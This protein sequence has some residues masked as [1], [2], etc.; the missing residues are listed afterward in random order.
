[1]AIELLDRVIVAPVTSTIH[2]VPSEVAVGVESGLKEPSAVNLDN[3]QT[4]R[5]DRLRRYVGHL[6]AERMREVCQALALATG[7]M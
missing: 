5:K 6:D 1:M 2:G 7:C 4:V 3:L